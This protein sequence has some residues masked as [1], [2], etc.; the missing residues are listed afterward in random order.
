ME[1]WHDKYNFGIARVKLSSTTGVGFG[2]QQ[3]FT[4]SSSVTPTPD[5]DMGGDVDSLSPWT[6]ASGDIFRG[7]FT[8]ESAA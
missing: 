4:G 7:N 5:A 6:W 3:A 8:Y 2:I 1:M